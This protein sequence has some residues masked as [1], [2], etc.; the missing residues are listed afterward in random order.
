MIGYMLYVEDCPY[1]MGKTLLEA[2]TA[3]LPF[4]AEARCVRIQ[5]LCAPAPS[6][7]WIYDGK[8][9]DWISVDSPPPPL[10]LQNTGT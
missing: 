9:K 2:Q 6:R 5:V 1:I 3:A 4:I 8:A 10:K 7:H